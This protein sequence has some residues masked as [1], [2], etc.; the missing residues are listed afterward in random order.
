MKIQFIVSSCEPG[1][2][3]NLLNIE[4]TQPVPMPDET[5]AVRATFIFLMVYLGLHA[6]LVLTSLYALCGVNN[7][8]LGRRSFPIFFAPWIIFWV[9]VIVL[10]VLA[11]G[12]Y[13]M[14][15]ITL[16]VSIG[17]EL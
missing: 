7:S 10:D 5:D 12:Y 15:S 2:D 11:T 16:S 3:W 13:I 8:C 1:V 6:V 4:S 9:E 17:I 14:D